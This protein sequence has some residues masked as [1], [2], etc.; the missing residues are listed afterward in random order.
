VAVRAKH[1]KI[2]KPVIE[3]VSVYVIEL[4]WDRLPIPLNIAAFFAACL[5]Q[6][7]A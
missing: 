2:L 4:K 5:F 7:E 6:A 1:S 3:A